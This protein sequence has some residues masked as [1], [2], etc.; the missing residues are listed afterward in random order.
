MNKHNEYFD[1]WINN[2]SADSRAGCVVAVYDFIFMHFVQ[3]VQ[4][5]YVFHPR[6]RMLVEWGQGF[7]WERVQQLE[8]KYLYYIAKH[9]EDFYILPNS[10]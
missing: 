2:V 3:R 5:M 8:Q 9:S 10:M 6:D 4:E 7:P 1:T